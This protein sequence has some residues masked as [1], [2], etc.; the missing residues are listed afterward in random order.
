MNAS[1]WSDERSTQSPQTLWVL[2]DGRPGHE[3]QSK[4]IVAAL[5]MRRHVQVH[6]IA[7]TLRGA[8]WRSILRAAARL[9]PAQLLHRV[10]PFSYRLT[11]WPNCP[12]TIVIGSGG[13]TLFMLGALSALHRVPSVFSGTTKRYPRKFLDCVLTVVPDAATNNVVLP[14]PPAEVHECTRSSSAGRAATLT[15]S[16]LIGGDGA[17]CV[18]DD[19]DWQRLAK[20]MAS[21]GA[22][23][24]WQL[25]TSRRTGVK[26]EAQ[27]QKILQA[28]AV[29]LERAI[30]WAEKPE[31]VMKELLC[32]SDFIV[33]TQDSLSMLAEAM[34]TGKTVYSFAPEQCHMTDNDAAA[35]VSYVQRGFLKPLK[36]VQSIV[37]EHEPMPRSKT[38]YVQIDTAV[39]AAQE[40]RQ[41][42]QS[43][44]LEYAMRQSSLNNVN[45]PDHSHEPA[46][47]LGNHKHG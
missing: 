34:Y 18:F 42:R 3:S 19:A 1:Q 8:L 33:C 31:R 36:E 25:S 16:V 30:W 15:G 47:H 28:N 23:V 4:G 10:L 39:R 27:L 13:D 46:E 2:S 21:Q 17:G 40:R 38:V 29:A 12:P 5:E 14:L 41:R 44:S 6:W 37:V 7:V 32:D 22:S 26:H 20:W 24:R 45:W 9:L 11:D 35:V 43:G